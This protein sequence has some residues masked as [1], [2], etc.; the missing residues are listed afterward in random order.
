MDRLRASQR[1][2]SGNQT[3]PVSGDRNDTGEPSPDNGR[4]QE[5]RPA[6][7][8]RNRTWTVRTTALAVSAGKMM[9]NLPRF[10]QRLTQSPPPDEHDS[11]D[12]EDEAATLKIKEERLLKNIRS[13]RNVHLIK[14]KVEDGARPFSALFNT[15]T[16]TK[17][18]IPKVGWKDKKEKREREREREASMRSDG[19]R[20]SAIGSQKSLSGIGKLNSSIGQRRNSVNNVMSIPEE[21]TTPKTVDANGEWAVHP[22]DLDYHRWYLFTL[23][24]VIYNSLMLPLDLMFYDIEPKSTAERIRS[25]L[26]WF[27]TIIDFVFMLDLWI[28]FHVGLKNKDDTVI[29]SSKV[30]AK[31]YFRGTFV[32]DLVSSIPFDLF[33][34]IFVKDG[35][36]ESDDSSTL[37][38]YLALAKT[39]RLLRINRLAKYMSNQG[40]VSFIR[41]VRILFIYIMLAHWGGCLFYIVMKSAHWRGGKTWLSESASEL[42]SAPEDEPYA[43]FSYYKCPN[44]NGTNVFVT[45]T[46]YSLPQADQYWILLYTTTMVMMGD[47]IDAQNNSERVLST[48]FTL[49]GA[50]L[51]AMMFGQMTQIVQGLDREDTRYD[52]LMSKVND[53]LAS[54]DLLPETSDRIADY[55]EFQWR[56]NSGMDRHQFLNSLSPCLRNE[57]LLSVYADLVSNVSFFKGVQD[58]PDFICLIVEQLTTAFFLPSDVIVHEGELTTSLSYMY[59]I[60]LGTVAVYHPEEP[61]KIVHQMGEGSFFGEMSYLD[62]GSRRT[63]SVCALT[64]CD[65]ALLQFAEIDKLVE[66]FPSFR[67]HLDVAMRKHIKNFKEGTF[68]SKKLK[69]ASEKGYNRFGANHQSPTWGE[70]REQERL[71]LLAGEKEDKVWHIGEKKEHHGGEGDGEASLDKSGRSVTEIVRLSSKMGALPPSSSQDA[72]G[73]PIGSP[74]SGREIRQLYEKERSQKDLNPKR[75]SLRVATSPL[76]VGTRPIT[77]EVVGEDQD[78]A[79]QPSPRISDRFGPDLNPRRNAP[80]GK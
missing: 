79:L 72:V 45:S 22:D 58:A 5:E 56:M 51:T 7:P 80:A 50:C 9:Q 35:D 43:E 10:T 29:V 39:F 6:D 70:K 62:M 20:G 42:G 36:G 24:L 1:K 37:L 78:E 3:V 46:C 19:Y 33:V 75:N 52:E 12:S 69:V 55:Y 30:I 44:G 25:P 54:L 57:I 15:G 48:V 2:P 14:K 13:G 8:T 17:M 76:D 16:K 26:F 67:A 65:I 53:Q 71:R 40:I 73:S 11:S 38:S 66:S 18:S 61:E 68:L 59:F 47:S 31:N 4:P 27:E 60:T 32:V 63:S 23:I 41:I 77:E 64:N 74:D 28:T 49:I 21:L 34:L